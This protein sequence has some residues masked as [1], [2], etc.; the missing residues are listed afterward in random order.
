[1]HQASAAYEPNADL[2]LLARNMV[3]EGKEFIL[4]K[5]AALNLD[6]GF[7]RDI[8]R[9]NDACSDRERPVRMQAHLAELATASAGLA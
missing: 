7:V 1:V 6:T 3:S 9:V 5:A 2:S 4:A 8:M